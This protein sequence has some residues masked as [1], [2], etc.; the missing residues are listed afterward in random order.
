MDRITHYMITNTILIKSLIIATGF[1]M[2]TPTQ[3]IQIKSININNPIPTIKTHNQQNHSHYLSQ[4]THLKKYKI[5]INYQ[6]LLIKIDS[7][8]KKINSLKERQL[9]KIQLNTYL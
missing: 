9:I 2:I 4:N 8:C 1:M 7:H 5:M 6:N 3:D